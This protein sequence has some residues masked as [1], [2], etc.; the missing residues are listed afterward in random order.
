MC[1]ALCPVCA[2][3]QHSLERVLALL[4]DEPGLDGVGQHEACSSG[5]APRRGQG[6]AAASLFFWRAPV[7]RTRAG[8]SC[9]QTHPEAFLS[10]TLG[11]CG[12]QLLPLGIKVYHHPPRLLAVLVVGGHRS[13]S[14]ARMV[15]AE[16]RWQRLAAGQHSFGST[17]TAEQQMDTITRQRLTVGPAPLAGTR[18]AGHHHPS[19]PAPAVGHS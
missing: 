2:A 1:A 8:R 11:C 16:T 13:V 10:L 4:P 14:G 3:A 5:T 7:W 12:P 15:V 9:Q 17:E 6:S 18:A 19:P